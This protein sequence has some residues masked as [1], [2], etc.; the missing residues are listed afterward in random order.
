MFSVAAVLVVAF[1]FV[2]GVVHVK[3]HVGPEVVPLHCDV[4]ELLTWVT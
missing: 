4:H 2:D 1:A 3:G